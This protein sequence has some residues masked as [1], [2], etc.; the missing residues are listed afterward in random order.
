MGEAV[1][2]TE[3]RLRALIQA[4]QLLMAAVEPEDLVRTILQSAV[5]LVSAEACGIGLLDAGGEHLTF[6]RLAGAGA[7]E[8]FR[9]GADQGIAGWVAQRGEAVLSNDVASDDRFF[10]GVDHVTGVK[11]RSLLCAPLRRGEQVVGVIE[12]INHTTSGFADED[13]ELLKAFAGL[14]AIA[15]ERA[16]AFADMRDANEALRETIDDRYRLVVGESASMR[17]VVATAERAA[18][19]NATL[20]LLG[21]S[22]TGKEVLAR[23]VHGWSPRADQAFTAVHCAAL[24]RELLESELFGHEKGAFTGATAAKKGRFELANK[25]TL[26]LDEIGEIPAEMQVKLLR[27]LQEREFQRVGGTRDIHTDVRIIAATNRDLKE[28]MKRGE[29]REDLY[30]RLAV[31]TIALPPLRARPEDLP[32][33]VDELLARSCRE[34]NRERLEVEPS[35]LA[36]MCAYGWPG[37]VRELSNVIERAVVLAPGPKI[38]ENDL[39]PEVRGSLEA[40]EAPEAADLSFADAVDEFKRSAIRRALASTGGNQTRAAQALGMRQPNLS[41]LIKSLGI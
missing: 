20:L 38:T 16:S 5:R 9:I 33:L 25:G 36:R 19:S 10:A 24:S 37:N 14:G 12:A 18:A 35:A 17:E 27:V 1:I 21:E 15:L 30:Y 29:F 22:G 3:F 28:A 23:A 8:E 31:V 39:P 34:M 2:E 32:G 7:V 11:T 13:L 26:F 4:N 40:A 6:S 41:R